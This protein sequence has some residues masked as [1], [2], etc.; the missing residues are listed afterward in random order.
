MRKK[1]TTASV[2]VSL[3]IFSLSVI[4]VSALYAGDDPDGKSKSNSTG[5]PEEKPYFKEI[6]KLK[7]KKSGIFNLNLDIQIGATIA[8]TKFDLNTIDSTT[9]NINNNSTKVGPSIGAILSFDFLGFGFTTGLQYSSKGF[10]TINGDNAN[11]NFFNIPILFYFDF[12]V[13][14]KVIID[15]S[16]GPYVGLLMSSTND[17]TP[18]PPYKIKNFD[19][20]ITGDIQGAYMF[21]KHLGS[22]LGLKYEYGG[23]NNL[24]NN[25]KINRTTTQTFFIYTG[26]KFVL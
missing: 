23:I 20:G 9:A 11:L 1:I 7:A 14:K 5:N 17:N 13:G 18:L 21:A 6:K 4:S 26:I 3:I 25:L 22:I 24:G 12:N 2:Y 19:F 10:K 8:T 16:F 15:G